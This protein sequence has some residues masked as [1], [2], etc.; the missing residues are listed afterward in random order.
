MLPPITTYYN[1][2]HTTCHSLWITEY[3]CRCSE[4]FN[5]RQKILLCLAQFQICPHLFQVD[6]RKLLLPFML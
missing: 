3:L 4:G 5:A 1:D 6:G 2:Y